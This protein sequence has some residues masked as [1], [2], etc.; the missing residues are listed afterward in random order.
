MEMAQSR[1][2]ELVELKYMTVTRSTIIYEMP[3]AEVGVDSSPSPFRI[4]PPPQI[5]ILQVE[6]SATYYYIH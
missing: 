4:S 1:R 2:G 5:H 3:M 6:V